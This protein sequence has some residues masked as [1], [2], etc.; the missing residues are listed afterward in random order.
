MPPK[1]EETTEQVDLTWV[2]PSKLSTNMIFASR[3][4]D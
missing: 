1:K 3:R 4:I 2:A